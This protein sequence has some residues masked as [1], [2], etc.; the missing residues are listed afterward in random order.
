MNCPLCQAEMERGNLEI[1]GTGWGFMFFGLSYQ[2]CWFVPEDGDSEIVV[3]NAIG[4]GATHPASGAFRDAFR[5][6]ECFTL[7]APGG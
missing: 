3:S 5:C 7:V 6:P 2:H 4:R 1:R